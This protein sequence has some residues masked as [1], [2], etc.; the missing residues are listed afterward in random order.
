[1]NS[2]EGFVIVSFTQFTP[3]CLAREGRSYK[4]N[5]VSIGELL[6]IEFEFPSRDLKGYF[7]PRKSRIFVIG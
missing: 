6:S 1:M 7:A 4:D 2:K 3:I 5:L